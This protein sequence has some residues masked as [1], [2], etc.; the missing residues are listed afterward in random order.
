MWRFLSGVSEP[1]AKK[2][3]SEDQKKQKKDYEEEKKDRKWVPAWKR[4]DEGEERTWLVYDAEKTDA[5][6]TVQKMDD[7]IQR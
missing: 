1:P 7:D 3:K 6:C 5:L 4:T 2:S